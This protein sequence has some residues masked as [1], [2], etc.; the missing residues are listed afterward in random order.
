LTLNIVRTLLKEMISLRSIG[1]RY[2][3][4]FFRKTHLT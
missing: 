1:Y 2:S 4:I 3:V